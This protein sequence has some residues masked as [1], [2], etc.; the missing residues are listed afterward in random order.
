LIR[1]QCTKKKDRVPVSL[2]RSTGI[3]FKKFVLKG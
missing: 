2:Y 3:R 1:V